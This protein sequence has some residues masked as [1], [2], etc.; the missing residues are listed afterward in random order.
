MRCTWRWNWMGASICSRRNMTGNE[1]NFLK[2]KASGFYDSGIMTCFKELKRFW[3]WSG[4]ISEVPLYPPSSAL[5]APSPSR[6][7]V[8]LRFLETVDSATPGKSILPER[9]LS[10]DVWDDRP[11]RALSLW[12][13]GDR[14][15]WVM[16]KTPSKESSPK[17]QKCIRIPKPK[18]PVPL[19][20]ALWVGELLLS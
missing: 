10:L 3:K 9:T 18:S 19:D 13:R 5:R 1:R 20:R 7:K 14:L 8:F 16:V 2:I 15:R 4:S 17:D 11:Q 12:E 6:E